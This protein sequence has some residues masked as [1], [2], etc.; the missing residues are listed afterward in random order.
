MSKLNEWSAENLER[1]AKHMREL[2]KSMNAKAAI[3]LAKR[4]QDVEM[5]R[6]A[7]EA[8]KQEALK[9]QYAGEVERIRW[10]E[11]RRTLEL[12]KENEK[13]SP[14]AHPLPGT[15]PV[16]AP[17]RRPQPPPAPAAS[18]ACTCAPCSK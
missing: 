5:A 3:E 13:V 2:D 11:Q 12:K 18:R 1:A 16:L 17:S 14:R 4:E 10:E 7:T 15:S 9:A 6:S 8:K